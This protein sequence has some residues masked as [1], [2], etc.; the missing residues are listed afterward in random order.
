MLERESWQDGW[1]VRISM[2]GRLQAVRVVPAAFLS[3]WLG[4]WVLG[5]KFAGEM[6]L[7]TLR[8][9]FAPGQYLQSLPQPH[10]ALPAPA[11][12]FLSLWLAFWTVGGVFAMT[13][14][15]A[16]LFGSPVARWNDHELELAID[17]GPFTRSRRVAL[18]HVGEMKPGPLCTLVDATG[19]TGM[20]IGPFADASEVAQMREWL[21][22]AQHAGASEPE[23]VRDAA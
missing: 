19:R 21:L 5:E 8:D 12:A 11:L 10:H 1:Q 23:P 20:V 4:A 15:V 7:A 14:L 22:E 13:T 3:M 6:V 18:A 17:V 9:R 16:V 2:P